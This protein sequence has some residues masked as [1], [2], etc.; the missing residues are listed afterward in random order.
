MKGRKLLQSLIVILLSP[1]IS[2]FSQDVSDGNKLSNPVL[3]SLRTKG[4]IFGNFQKKPEI[5][6]TVSQAVK[7][8]QQRYQSQ[9]WNNA[10]D[11]F[12]QAMG[13]LIFNASNPPV[14]STCLGPEEV[15]V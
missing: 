3:D 9:Y 4:V 15:P 1:W 5:E 10:S 12:R 14:D 7:F 13:Q 8:L 11:P 2:V 6:L